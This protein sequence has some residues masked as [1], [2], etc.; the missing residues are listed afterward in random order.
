M[1]AFEQKFLY[2][3]PTPAFVQKKS[4]YMQGWENKNLK[5]CVA[6]QEVVVCVST[7]EVFATDQGLKG[8]HLDQ[9]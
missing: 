9:G 6:R 1:R 3:A 2:Q 4:L 5:V 7:F 8:G